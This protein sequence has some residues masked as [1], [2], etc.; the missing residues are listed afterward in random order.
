M[1][2]DE[3]AKQKASENSEASLDRG[4]RST[5]PTGIISPDLNQILLTDRQSLKSNTRLVVDSAVHE[6]IVIGIRNI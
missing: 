5:K 2:P 3:H 4:A 6:N 1:S